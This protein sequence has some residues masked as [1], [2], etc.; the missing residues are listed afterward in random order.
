MLAQEEAQGK[1]F[2]INLMGTPEDI[3]AWPYFSAF[4][5]GILKYGEPLEHGLLNICIFF[6]CQSLPAALI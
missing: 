1:P 6:H 4:L 5:P 2:A 3:L